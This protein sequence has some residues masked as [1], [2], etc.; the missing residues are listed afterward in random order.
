M[1]RTRAQWQRKQRGGS[2]SQLKNVVE[3][4]LIMSLSNT[5]CGG[6]TN[7]CIMT[8]DNRRGRTTSHDFG[9]IIRN[10]Q[11][12]LS[13]IRLECFPRLCLNKQND[14]W[15]ERVN[16]ENCEIA[17]ISSCFSQLPLNS[18]PL[19]EDE[20]ISFFFCLHS[21][22]AGKQ[23]MLS[24]LRLKHI[25]HYTT[26]SNQKEIRMIHWKGRDLF[27]FATNFLSVISFFCCCSSISSDKCAEHREKF[28]LCHE[29][30]RNF[31]M[32]QFA[33]QHM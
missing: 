22:P 19:S 13:W 4:N 20:M 14:F 7:I 23:P 18:H 33:F 31:S 16:E 8:N 27:I 6:Q 11:F 5:S 12:T 30:L 29:I 1:T 9:I 15:E 3:L 21:L 25:F 10:S 26:Q 24:Y 28:S 17:S 2:K 32:T